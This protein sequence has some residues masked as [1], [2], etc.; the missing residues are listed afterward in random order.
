M[1]IV[2]VLKLNRLQWCIH[3]NWLVFMLVMS[4]AVASEQQSVTIPAALPPPAAPVPSP[5]PSNA[6][7]EFPDHWL[8][9]VRIQRDA[10]AQQRQALHDERRRRREQ[11]NQAQAQRLQS[12]HAQRRQQL[13]ERLD[14]DYLLRNH[15]LYGGYI[16]WLRETPSGLSAPLSEATAPFDGKNTTL[17]PAADSALTAPVPYP[18]APPGWDKGWY[19]R[20]W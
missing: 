20:G 19:Y 3:I 6:P 9:E 15:P 4:N 12:A 14:E 18:P 5:P 16:P 10:L 13:H 17:S 8:D 7:L 2:N 11:W 1:R